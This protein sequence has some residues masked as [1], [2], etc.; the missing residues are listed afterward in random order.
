[1]DNP[2]DRETRKRR[3]EWLIERLVPRKLIWVRIA[4]KRIFT[5]KGAVGYVSRLRKF[6][7]DSIYRFRNVNDQEVIPSDLFGV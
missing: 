1:M 3:T 2:T 5:I 4:K 7:P 6:Y